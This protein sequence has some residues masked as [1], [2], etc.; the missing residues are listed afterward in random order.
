MKLIVDLIYERGITGMRESISN[1]AEFGDLVTG[2]R[3]INEATRQEMK[4][5]LAEIQSGEFAGRW[6]EENKKGKPL[7]R[8]LA[9][10]DARHSIEQVG[11]DLRKMMNWIEK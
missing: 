7:F 3:I 5:V 6:V 4:K 8:K 9:E 10:E 2:K 1:T 11:K